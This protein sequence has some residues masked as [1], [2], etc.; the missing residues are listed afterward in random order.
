MTK[1]PPAGHEKMMTP[2]SCTESW[3][4]PGL[5]IALGLF[6]IFL[7][8]ESQSFSEVY[9]PTSQTYQAVI[10]TVIFG[11][12]AAIGIDR[13]S[14]CKAALRALTERRAEAAAALAARR[15]NADLITVEKVLITGGD[16]ITVGKWTQLVASAYDSTGAVIV[17][18]MV[19]WSSSNDTIAPVGFDGLVRARAAGTAVITASTGNV[20]GTVH[21]VVRGE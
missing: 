4:G 18:R 17:D 10:G 5:D 7:V 1:G 12:S 13:V 3:T 21:V 15:R 6:N 2:F 8:M 20:V 9:D 14:R 11:S 19:T 16:T